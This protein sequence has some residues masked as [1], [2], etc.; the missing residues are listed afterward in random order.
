VDAPETD[1][2]VFC[3]ERHLW[4]FRDYDLSLCEEP[5]HEHRLRELTATDTGR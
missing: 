4:W 2:E 5:S 1:Y 3:A